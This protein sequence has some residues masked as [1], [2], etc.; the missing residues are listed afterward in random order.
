M[1]RVVT[2][3]R[4]SFWIEHSISLAEFIIGPSENTTLSMQ[5]ERMLKPGGKSCGRNSDGFQ[6]SICPELLNDSF[7]LEAVLLFDVVGLD[8]ADVVRTCAAQDCHQLAERVTE[9]KINIEN[10]S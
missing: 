6:Y 8:A 2:P 1:L 9:L 4:L 7:R 5:F 10:K 3:H